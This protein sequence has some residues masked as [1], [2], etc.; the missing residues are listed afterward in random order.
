MIVPKRDAKSRFGE[1]AE[2]DTRI[3]TLSIGF[4]SRDDAIY[5]LLTFRPK[6][7][8]I[9]QQPS[10]SSQCER[11]TNHHHSI[12]QNPGLRLLPIHDCLQTFGKCLGRKR[13]ETAES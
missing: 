6:K 5:H 9:D 12:S 3:L 8:L 4:R 10:A 2:R 7:W 1:G 11:K 13:K